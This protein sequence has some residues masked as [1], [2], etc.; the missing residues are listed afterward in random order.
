MEPTLKVLLALWPWRP[1]VLFVLTLTGGTYL[2]GWRRLRRRRASSAAVLGLASYLGGLTAIG[3]A[4]LSPVDELGARLFVMHMVQHELLTMIAPP[5]LLLANPLPP[6][7]WGL[8]PG[9]RRR[10]GRL[11]T[12]SAPL[13]R[14]WRALTMMWVAWPLHVATVWGWHLSP[15]YEAALGSELIHN[16]EHLSFFLTALLFWWPI[17]NPA[18]RLH[19][20]IPHGLRIAYVIPSLFQS[21]ALGAFFAFISTKVVYPSYLVAPRLWGLTALQDQGLGGMLMMEVEGLIY[22]ATALILMA[23]LLD[24]EERMARLREAPEVRLRKAPP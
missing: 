15:G 6:L 12:P 21:L 20:H 9:P 13:R 2:T 11:L 8:P 5:L 18:P 16:L 24:R 22:L 4:L 17:I 3:I 14:G 19:G 1:E 23:R 10:V 7:L